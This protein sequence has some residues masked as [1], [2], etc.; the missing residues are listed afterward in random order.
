MTIKINPLI[1][2]IFIWYA[3]V[4]VVLN[5]P[6]SSRRSRRGGLL[7]SISL[8]GP[9]CSLLD[10]G[11]LSGQKGISVNMI[12]ILH[13]PIATELGQCQVKIMTYL[14]P[15]NNSQCEK[16]AFYCTVGAHLNSGLCSQVNS[17]RLV[18]QCNCWLSF[19]NFLGKAS[20]CYAC[21]RMSC[22]CFCCSRT[23]WQW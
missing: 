12:T 9:V 20:Y 16:S 1:Q 4:R 13:A 6:S 10:S 3:F 11:F 18:L 17:T 22:Y 23:S 2:G 21:F 7:C 19:T 14:L 5:V 8:Q 15:M